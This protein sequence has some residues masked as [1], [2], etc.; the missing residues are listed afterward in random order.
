MTTT[1]QGG[2]VIKEANL[3]GAIVNVTIDGREQ[4]IS[5]PWLKENN[6]NIDDNRT[7]V[8]KV[9]DNIMNTLWSI[10]TFSSYVTNTDQ[11]TGKY[12][13]D[14]E[15]DKNF[16]CSIIAGSHSMLCYPYNVVTYHK[17]SSWL[18]KCLNIYY[19]ISKNYIPKHLID[20]PNFIQYPRSSGTNSDA[21]LWD[22][23]QFRIHKSK[24]LKDTEEHFYMRGHFYPDCKKIDLDNLPSENS[25]EW[26]F[27]DRPLEEIAEINIVSQMTIRFNDIFTDEELTNALTEDVVKHGVMLYF[28]NMHNEWVMDT[29]MPIV[30]RTNNIT[31]NVV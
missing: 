4:Q 6:N 14:E 15:I 10:T 28:N 22:S 13:S 21:V 2:V 27:K 9:C 30:N 17:D 31:I 12:Y 5:S 7:D 23:G 18:M 29:L 25:S 11:F 20:F 26:L 8:E 19:R 3:A 24:S 1:V 16:V